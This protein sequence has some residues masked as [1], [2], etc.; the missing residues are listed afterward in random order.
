MS[1]Q[2]LPSSFGSIWLSGVDEVWRL[3]RWPTW[4]HLIY[5]NI[6]ILAILNLHVIS[7]LP[8]KFGLN[9][10]YGL[11]DVF[12]RISKWPPRQPSWMSEW[13]KFSSS[14]SPM[15][16]TKFQLNL[17]YCL[18]PDIVSR[19][20]SWPP[21]QPSWISEQNKFSNSKSPCH[22]NASHHVWAQYDLPFDRRRGLKVW[23]W[24][25]WLPSWISEQ[26][27]FSNSEPLCCSNVPPIK[28]QLNPTYG[29]EEISYEWF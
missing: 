21:W 25:P 10:H 22:T 3:S 9:P 20:S 17:T 1:P 14:E 23:R 26:N 11:G 24:P 19:F 6:T 29:S 5:W 16:P 2:C 7:M 4:G 27:V 13:N 18:E 15:P 28:F 12:W 8:I